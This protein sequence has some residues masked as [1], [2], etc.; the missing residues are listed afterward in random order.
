VGNK[1]KILIKL[2]KTR[3]SEI[4]ITLEGKRKWAIA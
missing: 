1:K 2:I 3:L 4:K